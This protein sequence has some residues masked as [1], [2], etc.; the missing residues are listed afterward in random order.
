MNMMAGDDEWEADHPG[1]WVVS[2][3]HEGDDDDDLGFWS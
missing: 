2:S 1:R 3:G